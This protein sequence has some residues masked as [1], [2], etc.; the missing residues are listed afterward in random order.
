MMHLIAEI[1]TIVSSQNIDEENNIF[2]A[3]TA[4]GCQDTGSVGP[5]DKKIGNANKR[6]RERAARNQWR[7]CLKRLDT[8]YAVWK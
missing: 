7:T 3:Y 5:V 4:L 6:K 1:I 8:I 2:V